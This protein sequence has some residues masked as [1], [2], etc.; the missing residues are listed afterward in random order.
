MKTWYKR[1]RRVFIYAFRFILISLVSI[2][3]GY[4]LHLI[5]VSPITLFFTFA[6]I[7]LLALQLIMVSH[8]DHIRKYPAN[9]RYSTYTP[10]M[11]DPVSIANRDT[12]IDGYI[13]VIVPIVLIP[14]TIIASMIAWRHHDIGYIVLAGF[15]ILM[16]NYYFYVAEKHHKDCVE[17]Y[18]LHFQKF[19][20][21][22]NM[23]KNEDHV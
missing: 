18:E 22:Y 12:L 2:G 15:S 3:S 17:W 8:A 23:S 16:I 20:K 11:H 6:W 4:F 1:N 14:V 13:N 7:F 5:S 19:L 9:V 21:D 10:A